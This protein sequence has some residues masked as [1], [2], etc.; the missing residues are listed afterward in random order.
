LDLITPTAQL[1]PPQYIFTRNRM[2]LFLR[3]ASTPLTTFTSHHLVLP[4]HQH[5]LVIYS[6]TTFTSPPS[7]PTTSCLLPPTSCLLPTQCLFFHHLKLFIPTLLLHFLQFKHMHGVSFAFE[8]FFGFGYRIIPIYL[9]LSN[10]ARPS[11]IQKGNVLFYYPR[12]TNHR[13]GKAPTISL[14]S[15]DVNILSRAS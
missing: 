13:L 15:C 11:V 12:V 8:H 3:A 7:L 2:Y 10:R 6:T 14:P 1:P 4:L 9:F 5:H